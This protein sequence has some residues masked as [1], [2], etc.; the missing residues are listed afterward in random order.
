M[1]LTVSDLSVFTNVVDSE[2]ESKMKMLLEGAY[3]EAE[4]YTGRLFDSATYTEYDGNLTTDEWYY[5]PQNIPILSISSLTVNDTT[6]TEDTDFYVEDR[7]I[8]FDDAQ[9]L[10]EPHALKIVY[11]AGWDSSTF[12]L[13]LKM[14]ILKL[15]LRND[16]IGQG[17]VG[18]DTN[19]VTFSI[20]EIYKVFDRYKKNEL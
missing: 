9:D 4:A 18:V 19:L 12:P 7:R 14:A 20:Q 8:V 10:S 16:M 11:T 6:L 15:A 1:I 3:A 5:Y 2:N 13:D 17:N